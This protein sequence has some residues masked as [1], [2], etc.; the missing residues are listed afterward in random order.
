MGDRFSV[1]ADRVGDVAVLSVEGS[2]D[3]ATVPDFAD[4]LW[5]VI[6]A[7]APRILVDLTDALFIDS[8]MVELLLQAAE[9]VRRTGGE[10]AICCGGE[11]VGQVLDLC[12]V[13]RIVPV[14][15]T[16]EQAIAALG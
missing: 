6:D 4:Q 3:L 14:V 15:A 1:Q 7:G 8:R 5:R 2:A 9:R 16:R 12:G 10:V 11:G 13:A